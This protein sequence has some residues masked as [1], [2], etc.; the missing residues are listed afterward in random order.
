MK[1]T[2]T[3][4]T[5]ISFLLTLFLAAAPAQEKGPGGISYAGGPGDAM[6]TAVIIKGAPNS[7]AGVKAEYYY[8]EMKFGRQN[9]DWKLERQRLMG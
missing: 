7:D 6:E 4:L 3:L 9:S 1:T 2:L 5:A 8:L